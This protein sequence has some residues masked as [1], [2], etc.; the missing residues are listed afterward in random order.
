MTSEELTVA[1]AVPLEA[2]HVDRIRAVHPSV[3]V[4]Y[5]A[6]LLPPERFPADHAG[7]PAFRRTPE[8][9]QRYWTMLRGADILYGFPNENT[10]GLAAIAAGN[11]RLKW[12]QAMAAGAGGA[13]KASA[14]DTATL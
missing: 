13:V 5:D 9:E 11:Q 4:L 1:I 2:E 12:I 8:Q 7:D 3:K 10:A 14:L 6:D